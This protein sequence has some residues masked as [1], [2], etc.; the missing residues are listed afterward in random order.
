[1]LHDDLDVLTEIF[2][3]AEQRRTHPALLDYKTIAE[4]RDDAW[5]NLHIQLTD[6]IGSITTQLVKDEHYFY[7]LFSIPIVD[8]DN[9][10][11]IIK[12]HPLPIFKNGLMHRPKKYIKLV[13]VMETSD[14]F[15]EITEEEM[16]KCTLDAH[17]CQLGAPA[18]PKT[19][20]KCGIAAWF[21][22]EEKCVY[23]P[24]DDPPADFFLTTA[25]YT[26]YAVENE[27]TLRIHCH[28][29][30]DPQGQ[31]SPSADAKMTITGQGVFQ[32]SQSC[33]AKTEDGR[34]IRPTI[35]RENNILLTK[36][37]NFGRKN[38]FANS[39]V[40]VNL[41]ND[42]TSDIKKTLESLQAMARPTTQFRYPR[43]NNEMPSLLVLTLLI[44][45][46]IL[47]AAII[48]IACCFLLTRRW[49]TRSHNFR[50]PYFVTH[51][52]G[53]T[54]YRPNPLDD[55]HQNIPLVRQQQPLHG[56]EETSEG[57]TSD[58][59]DGIRTAPI[60][61]RQTPQ[62]QQQQEPATAGNQAGAAPPPAP[63]PPPGPSNTSALNKKETHKKTRHERNPSM[64][65][66]T[67]LQE[68]SEKVKAAHEDKEPQEPC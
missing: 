50:R 53:H 65:G 64:A 58:E 37:L 43:K 38:P 15:I 36:T 66:K 21:E 25:N 51:P 3:A 34:T 47:M 2:F 52:P 22:E 62:Q 33:T 18:Q 16:I 9:K 1:M 45:G 8:K 61:N 32:L 41:G 60:D 31:A 67:F 4:L 55:A 28:K 63:P 30:I 11:S 48:V 6:D 19:A 14:D 46:L 44:I 24:Q 26:V 7:G 13:A 39:S 12:I 20:N 10:A 49:R 27:H 5:R 17:R 29:G 56:I 40:E 35:S 68:L 57:N 59:V 23:E 42:I 54:I